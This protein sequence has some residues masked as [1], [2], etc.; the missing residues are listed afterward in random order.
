MATNL[1][2]PNTQVGTSHIA[3]TIGSRK[4]LGKYLHERL[5]RIPPAP[6]TSVI[7]EEITESLMDSGAPAPKKGQAMLAIEGFTPLV[8]ALLTVVEPSL[9]FILKGTHVIPTI[10]GFDPII[11]PKPIQGIFRAPGP[12]A[13]EATLPSSVIISSKMFSL[14]PNLQTQ[15]GVVICMPKSFPYQDSHHVL[16][17]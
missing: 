17:K 11:L 16:W 5:C 13:L 15:E 12:K 8:L 9:G 10:R 7:I 14:V 3:M 1:C 6:S 4:D 2:L